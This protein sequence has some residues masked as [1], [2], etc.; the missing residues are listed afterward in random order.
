MLRLGKDRSTQIAQCISPSSE[1]ETTEGD[2]TRDWVVESWCLKMNSELDPNRFRFTPTNS[3]FSL[4]S[5]V[6][7]ALPSSSSSTSSF[8]SGAMNRARI[9][10][11]RLEIPSPGSSFVAHSIW[12]LSV[13]DR[14]STIVWDD[15]RLSMVP[16]SEPRRCCI[17]LVVV[18]TRDFSV[19][20]ETSSMVESSSSP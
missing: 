18:T 16:S 4:D 15:N 13:R 3:L 6:T 17:L 12:R 2:E 10:L 20:R 14:V 11:C 1:S 9:K 5:L 7:E 19:S 8:S